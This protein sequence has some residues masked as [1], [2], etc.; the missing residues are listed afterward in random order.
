MS[1]RYFFIGK[2]FYM[3]KKVVKAMSVGLS[4]ITIASTMNVTVQA[5]ETVDGTADNTTATPAQVQTAPTQE[6]QA[7]AAAESIQSDVKDLSDDFNSGD[8]ELAAVENAADNDIQARGVTT[9]DA[10][11]NGNENLEAAKEAVVNAD[12]AIQEVVSDEN[13]KNTEALV[14]AAANAGAAADEVEGLV[15]SADVAAT[16]ANDAAEI[17]KA[18]A[19]AASAAVATESKSDAVEIIAEASASVA[20]A[21][22][23]YDNAATVLDDVQSKYAQALIDYNNAVAY[24]NSVA[25]DENANLDEAITQLNNATTALEDLKAQ[26]EAAKYNYVSAAAGAIIAADNNEDYVKAIMQYYYLPT[27]AT[28]VEVKFDYNNGDKDDSNFTV[29]Y[30]INGREISEKYAW[31]YNWQTEEVTIAKCELRYEYVDGNGD[32]QSITQAELNAKLT[33]GTAVARYKVGNSYY[34]EATLHAGSQVDE[35]AYVMINSDAT[36]EKEVYELAPEQKDNKNR[37]TY[38]ETA[39]E[40]TVAVKYFDSEGHY[41]EK[42]TDT[43]TKT[44]TTYVDGQL[45]T[46]QAN[47]EADAKN[48]ANAALAQAKK[49]NGYTSVSETD[50]YWTATGYYVPVYQWTTTEWFKTKTHTAARRSEKLFSQWEIIEKITGNDKEK[51]DA[52]KDQYKEEDGFFDVEV[53]DFTWGALTTRVS[54]YQGYKVNVEADKL[55]DIDSKINTI[56]KNERKPV[57]EVESTWYSLGLYEKEVQKYYDVVGYDKALSNISTFYNVEYTGVKTKTETEERSRIYSTDSVDSETAIRAINKNL[58]NSNNTTFQAL[59]QNLIARRDAYTNL[60][61]QV[62]TA[63]QNLAA[64]KQKVETIKNNISSLKVVETE[65]EAKL[66]AWN[67]LLALAETNVAKA[68]Q[69][70]EDAQTALEEAQTAFDAK[71]P[72][73]APYIPGDGGYN[74]GGGAAAEETPI[75]AVATTTTTDEVVEADTTEITDEAVPAAGNT[76]NTRANRTNR[77]TRTANAN[78]DADADATTIEDAE[79]PLAGD[80]AEDVAEEKDEP[81]T[82]ADEETAKAGGEK[83]NFF[84]RTWWGWLLALIAAV[85]GGTAYAKKKAN[86][87]NPTK[88]NK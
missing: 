10:E 7:T 15:N 61:T 78:A 70:L 84:A 20:E 44:T 53:A 58:F 34:T 85:A 50:K 19:E 88:S 32:K 8:G 25:D 16:E 24:L 79:T 87:K 5:E 80:T 77:T 75:Y 4:A 40:G 52:I 51:K 9:I 37:T 12:E 21:E 54:F 81:V 60:L 11:F 65:Y 36:E 55:K 31:A 49:D 29:S 41:V 66:A 1:E 28:D 57:T 39:V 86:A 14:D 59:C 17:A 22:E 72:A 27:V 48:K 26:V 30:K 18:K 73:P 82:I 47:S 71:Y 3:K 74:Y 35:V 76:T 23:K 45:V 63:E 6:Q 62:N 56:A 38:K 42:Y 2:G 33:A 68:A 43:V 67:G 64:A 13:T 83:S 69:N 46:V